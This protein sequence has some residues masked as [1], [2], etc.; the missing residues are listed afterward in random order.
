VLVEVD[1]IAEGAEQDPELVFVWQLVDE[2]LDFAIEHHPV[3][4]CSSFGGHDQAHGLPPII[5]K[6]QDLPSLYLGRT[7]LIRTR[8]RTGEFLN[9]GI[10]GIVA[11]DGLNDRGVGVCCNHVGQLAR[12]PSGVPAAVLL[13]QVLE[14]AR[15][16]EHA[17]EL[18]TAAPSASGMNYVLGDRRGV[19]DIEVSA[20]DVAYFRPSAVAERVWHTNH[21][22]A[23]DRY[24]D[25]IDFWNGLS[26]AEAGNTRARFEVLER[27]LSDP[28]RPLDLDLARHVLSCRDGPVSAHPEDGF[29][30]VN[31]LVIEFDAEP[32]LHFCA[33]PPDR[34]EFQR[35]GFDEGEG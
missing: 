13:R 17:V 32:A 27:E 30:T 6:T 24:V 10:V 20:H 29:P 22:L 12:S 11:Q 1:A 25:T 21:P 28:S 33:G 2:W 5:A 35:F 26:D 19:V 14:H 4:K 15:S 8:T 34:G 3:A 23:N 16:T 9:S 7:A 18:L 31:G